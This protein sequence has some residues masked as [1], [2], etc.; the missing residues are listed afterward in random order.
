[1]LIDLQLQRLL[2]V[3]GVALTA[4]EE[5]GACIPPYFVVPLR[6][7]GYP[8]SKTR[9]LD[10]GAGRLSA[11]VECLDDRA[12]NAGDGL[13]RIDPG[14]HKRACSANCSERRANARCGGRDVPLQG[15]RPDRVHSE[16]SCLGDP[17]V[18]EVE[19]VPGAHLTRGIEGG[20]G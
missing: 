15:T 4:D 19:V 16:L 11:G 1:M 2:V 10:L 14:A 6:L 12:R 8:L 5:R 20:T 7:D 3:F 9:D 18:N 17:S 13:A